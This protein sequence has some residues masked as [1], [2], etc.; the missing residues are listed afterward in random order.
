MNV[1]S[2]LNL[3]HVSIERSVDKTPKTFIM[4]NFATINKDF[5]SWTVVAKLSIWDVCGGPGYM[6]ALDSVISGK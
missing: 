4:E 2:T 6:A 1:N 5:Y 3:G